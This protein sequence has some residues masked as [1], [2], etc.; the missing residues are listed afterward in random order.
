MQ[1]LKEDLKNKEFLILVENLD[2]LWQLQHFIEK[3]DLLSSHSTRS[4]KPKE[5][6]R[7]ER[8]KV[9]VELQVEKVEL[10]KPSGQLRVSGRIVSGRP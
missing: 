5:S 2:D 7:F 4:F 8:K 1:L 9:F 10:H 6:D 3:H